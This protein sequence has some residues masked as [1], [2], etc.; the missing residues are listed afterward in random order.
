M[1]SHAP[2]PGFK[3][4]LQAMAT[5]TLILTTGLSFGFVLPV[6][7]GGQRNFQIALTVVHILF[8][9]S[10]VCL[11]I[12]TAIVDVQDPAVTAPRGGEQY[13]CGTC[14]VGV[15]CPYSVGRATHMHVAG[16]SSSWHKAT[17]RRDIEK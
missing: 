5:V 15:T 10:A 2:T 8:V 17:S 4:F 12:W 11:F 3:T 14:Q 7:S 9:V 16:G 13:F 6:A 1:R